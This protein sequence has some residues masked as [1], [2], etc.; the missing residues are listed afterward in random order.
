LFD[1]FY[2]LH[3]NKQAVAGEQLAALIPMLL[4]E[5]KPSLMKIDDMWVILIVCLN[6]L[7]SSVTMD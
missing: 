3:H 2:H 7:C 6:K 1:Y 5:K 4:R